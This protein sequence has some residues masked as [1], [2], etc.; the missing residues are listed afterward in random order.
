M[1][2]KKALQCIREQ[3]ALI[4][5]QEKKITWLNNTLSDNNEYHKDVIKKKDEYIKYLFDQWTAIIVPI[6]M[7]GKPLQNAIFA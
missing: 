7:I 1:Q 5:E 4:E 6:L 3:K 2:L